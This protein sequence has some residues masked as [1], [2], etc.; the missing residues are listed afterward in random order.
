MARIS[1]GQMKRAQ[2]QMKA[3]N[4]TACMISVRL[5]FMACLYG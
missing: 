2:N 4:A 3:V 1:G 5:K